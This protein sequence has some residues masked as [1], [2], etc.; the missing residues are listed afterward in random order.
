MD[1]LLWSVSD[2][3]GT[4][5]LNREESRNA[6]TFDMI[7][8]WA[9]ILRTVKTDDAVRVI[10]LTGAGDRAFCSGVDLASISNAN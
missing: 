10:V 2:G 9:D 6:F 4:I 1:D 5:C 3:V 7:R 8:T